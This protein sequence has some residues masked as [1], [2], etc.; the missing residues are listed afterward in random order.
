MT[1][2]MSS[3]SSRADSAVEPTRSQNMT[4]SWRRS[5]AS[6]RGGGVGG[7]RRPRQRGVQRLDRGHHL[8]PMA[9]GGDAEILEIVD[10][11]LRQHR[12]V[13]FVV[14]ERRLVLP[15]AKRSA[16]NSRHPCRRPQTGADDGP[17][18]AQCPQ[19]RSTASVRDRQQGVGF[20]PF[21]EPSAN[22]RPFTPSPIA[23]AHARKDERTAPP[24]VPRLVLSGLNPCP[25][26]ARPR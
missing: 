6:E 25:R 20:D 10:R 11:Q 3:G 18:R 15:E 17:T 9:D 26:P 8:A 14:A 13:D 7:A 5:A 12:A 16:A 22:D 2:R 19:H 23:F 1:W 21:A 24:H 4:V